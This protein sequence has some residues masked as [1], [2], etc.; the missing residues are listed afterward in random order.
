[1]NDIIQRLRFDSARCET[2]FSKGVATNI[3]EAA[4]EIER[5]RAAQWPAEVT[6]EMCEAVYKLNLGENRLSLDDVT[7]I[8]DTFKRIHEQTK[9]DKP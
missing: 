1:M 9:A 6:P 5:L 7:D 8:Y 2:Q 4:A 3:D